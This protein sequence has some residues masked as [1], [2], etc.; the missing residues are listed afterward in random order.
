MSVLNMQKIQLCALKRNR[1]K[2]LTTLQR[3]GVME[4]TDIYYD[5]S[6]FHLQKQSEVEEYVAEDIQLAKEALQVMD[7]YCDKKTK[8]SSLTGRKLITSEKY[9]FY[10]S[11][12]NQ[13]K[14]HALQVTRLARIITEEVQENKKRRAQLEA[15]VPWITLTIPF[16]CTETNC[17]AVFFGTLPNAW[18][19]S[20]VEELFS[21]PL[22]TTENNQ[23]VEV[24]VI[25]SSKLMTYIMVMCLK[26][27]AVEVLSILRD[28]S[29]SQKISNCNLNL[30]PAKEKDFIEE[31]ILV[32]EKKI[33]EHLKMIKEFEQDIEE[34]QFLSDDAEVRLGQCEV[35]KH[36]VETENV[37]VVSGYIPK[38]EIG[39]TLKRIQEQC[40]VAIETMDISEEEEVPIL[41]KNPAFSKPLEGTVK[42][43]SLPGKGEI[44]P[45][46]IMAVFYYILFG[47]M[48][49]DAAYGAIMVFGCTFALLKYKNME[50]TL[51][52]SL[53][54][55]LYCGISTIFWGVMFGSYFG[56]M[57]DVV[58]ETFFGHVISIP[59]VWFFPVNE[60]MK[61]LVFSMLFGIIHIYTG[62]AVK[63]Y[64]CIKQKDY[65]S[66]LY[67]VI[68]WY[69]VLTASL[70]LL[71][72]MDVFT[73]T[74]GLSFQ[75]SKEVGNIALV[76]MLISSAGIILTAGRESRNP[77]KRFLKGLYGYYGITGYLSD[78]LS[79]SRLLALGLASGVIC[80]VINMMASMVGG[81]FVGV[82][83]FIVIFI[84]GHAINIGIN[85]L[86]AYVHT[87]RLQYV[88]FF[89]KFYSGG[90]REFSPFSMRTKYFKLDKGER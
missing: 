58:S 15:L 4:V 29:F 57:V 27:Q 84:L 42:A 16:S 86:G 22:T 74:F 47:L 1:K 9:E 6:I 34:F 20:K 37:F 63:L 31:E 82:I 39:K 21:D 76:I 52:N 46:T 68:L 78:V 19:K 81:G 56:D 25:S 32:S 83:A 54:M 35:I 64:Q 44:D 11:K 50:N 48:L 71:L 65:K 60:P 18:E 67:D 36:L 89:G 24:E 49:A 12:Y 43:Y 3:C 75:L 38:D 79:Y 55:F 33:T 59:P 13:I 70:V 30:P 40:D 61:M 26:K 88:E 85:A 90:G 10:E 28:A 23:F 14:E 80:T 87:N 62:L 77:V 8:V 7:T 17:T 72:S 5:D 2:L 73:K 45:T 69:I 53:K 41:L 66:V 51:K